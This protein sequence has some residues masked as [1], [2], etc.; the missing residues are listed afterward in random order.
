M[1]SKHVEAWNK[2]IVK[3]KF[4]ASSWLI[5]E[6]NILRCTVSRT[7]KY[8]KIVGYAEYVQMAYNRLTGYCFSWITS[9]VGISY[10]V[11]QLKQ[12]P[13]IFHKCKRTLHGHCCQANWTPGVWRTCCERH[14]VQRDEGQYWGLP[15]HERAAATPYGYRQIKKRR[16]IS[17]DVNAG[18]EIQLRNSSMKGRSHT[19][20]THKIALP[21]IIQGHRKRRTGFKTAIT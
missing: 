11:I 10:D 5:T 4:C 16:G 14:I 3:Q 2:L 12:L 8:C 19:P 9:V 7:S 20:S 21:N 13:T 17:L 18:V 1:C 6:I 15:P